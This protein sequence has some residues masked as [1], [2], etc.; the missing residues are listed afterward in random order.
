[1]AH[2][3]Q[4][5]ASRASARQSEV[6]QAAT[7][8][9]RPLV[10]NE[11]GGTLDQLVDDLWPAQMEIDL[12]ARTEPSRGAVCRFAVRLTEAA[13]GEVP[14]LSGLRGPQVEFFD[15]AHADL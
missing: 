9:A 8:R 15:A 10:G 12:S 3:T 7:H 13:Q 11:A 6:Q 1:M 14:D 4:F 5:L 2:V